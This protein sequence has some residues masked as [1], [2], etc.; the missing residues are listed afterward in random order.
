MTLT[1]PNADEKDWLDRYRLFSV[2]RLPGDSFVVFGAFYS[3]ESDLEEGNADIVGDAIMFWLPAFEQL[4]KQ[5]N[6]RYFYWDSRSHMNDVNIPN[7]KIEHLVSEDKS[8]TI[9]FAQM[10][11]AQAC[12]S[13]CLKNGE[14]QACYYFD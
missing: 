1:F 12:Y 4:G 7:Y 11:H 9:V 6:A 8:E 3:K 10:N 5:V 14:P 13:F 2:E